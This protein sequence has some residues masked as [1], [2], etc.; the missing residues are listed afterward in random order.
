MNRKILYRY[1]S[2]Q[3]DT[4][5]PKSLVSMIDMLEHTEYEPLFL[6]TG[7]GPL[8]KQLNSRNVPVIQ[9]NVVSVS[10]KKPFE[11]MFTIYEKYK[12]LKQYDIDIVHINEFGWNLDVVLASKLIGIPVVLHCR[13]ATR[14]KPTNLNQFACSKILTVSAQLLHEL[15][16]SK[17]IKNK[18]QVLYNAVNID[19][20]VAAKTIRSELGFSESDVLICTIA[21]ICHRKG[22]DVVIDTALRVLKSEATSHFLIVGPE[23][24]GE[25][26]YV[27]TCKRRVQ[28]SGL[29]DNIHFLGS[30]DDIPEILN[31]VDIFF[32]PTRDEPFGRVITEAMA[33]QVPVVA[34]RIGGI[35]EIIN[36]EDAGVLVDPSND[37]AYYNALTP[38]IESSIKRKSMG[39]LG[40][41]SLFGRFDEGSIGKQLIEIY[42]AL[43]AKK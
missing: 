11:L 14:I 4:G 6:A 33:A 41:K 38:L 22:I 26:E 36:S 8:T 39:E 1:S 13:N 30:R 34:N 19:R 27:E 3:F 23:G 25:T 43:L 7:V 31:S 40:F 2:N 29:T 28:D 18:A 21:Q 37:D 5:S 9:S 10:L 16:C 42:D 35:P 20:Y 24:K 15:D 12:L 17:R 32:L